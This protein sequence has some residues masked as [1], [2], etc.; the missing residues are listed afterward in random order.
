MAII[1]DN[2]ITGHRLVLLPPTTQQPRLFGWIELMNGPESAGFIYLDDEARDPHLNL[3]GTYIVTAMPVASL[4]T[5]LSI[6]ASGRALRI[7][8]HDPES[9]GSSPSVFIEDI[10]VPVP[11]TLFAL[12]PEEAARA[13][14]IRANLN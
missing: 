11:E 5:L 3:A 7:R 10:A 12:P 1:K 4:D 9:F 2:P 6:L 13:A 8:Y 14:R